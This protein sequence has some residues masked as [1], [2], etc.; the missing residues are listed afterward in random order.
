MVGRREGA[1]LVWVSLGGRGISFFRRGTF[2][3]LRTLA[4]LSV[5]LAAAAALLGVT[6]QFLTPYFNGSETVRM[7]DGAVTG[8]LASARLSSGVLGDVP[9]F[10]LH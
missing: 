7:V 5:R 6:A 3:T 9:A 8:P 1:K 2:S 4:G 10:C